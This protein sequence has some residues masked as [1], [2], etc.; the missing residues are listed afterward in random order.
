MSTRSAVLVALSALVVGASG[1]AA[2]NQ[3][4]DAVFRVATTVDAPDAAVGDGQC[5]STAAGGGCTLR[6][7]LQEVGAL[8]GG[9][10]VVP[11]GRFT[12]SFPPGSDDATSGDLDLVGRVTVRGV[13]AGRTVVDG[14]GLDRVFEVGRGA[15]AHMLDM[16][17]TG[18]DASLGGTNQRISLGGG[19]LDGGTL[20]LDR[21]ALVGN[22]A[23]GGGGM[24]SIPR[25]R[26]V[27]RDSLIAD[28]RAYSGVGMRIDSG[29]TII[30]TTIHGNMM[31]EVPDEQTMLT[32]R[33]APGLFGI[34]V[35]EGTGWGGGI[36]HRGGADV[37]IV[38][39]TITGN[40][41]VRGGGGLASGQTYAPVSSAIALG[42]MTLA[43]TIVAGNTSR[44]GAGG[45]HVNAQ[46]IRSL[47]NN[48]DSDG[49]CFLT[50]AG[51]RPATEPRLGPLAPNG[52]PTRTGLCSPGARRLTLA[53]TASAPATTS[54]ASGARQAHAATSAPLRGR[55]P[56]GDHTRQGVIR[57]AVPPRLTAVRY[58][59]VGQQEPPARSSARG[60]SLGGTSRPWA[61]TGLKLWNWQ[62]A[63][64]RGGPCQVVRSTQRHDV[65][66]PDIAY[67][68]REPGRG[69]G[70]APRLTCGFAS[71][72]LC[73]LPDPTKL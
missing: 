7:A 56:A 31:M 14:A 20:T 33:P 64:S 34:L 21:M 15:T 57:E 30:N 58:W 62:S 10:V 67:S 52:G 13:G 73:A 45:C 40:H 5:A 28:N 59:R 2:S 66:I 16:T 41:A 18:G 49:T 70:G 50:A 3:P 6:A 11:A 26:P 51:D 43:N 60:L 29:A 42:E 1:A 71:Q 35:D 63:A 38:N 17:V 37:V 4:E 69:T 36:D 39:S 46:V 44:T 27:V 19:I 23:D 8:D 22:V 53:A 48:L 32:T 47:G 68:V 24:F 65:V 72:P 9:T 25:T 55:P 12:L 61:P 54:G